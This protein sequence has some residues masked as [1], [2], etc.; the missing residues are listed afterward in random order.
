MN[1]LPIEKQILIASM[2]CEGSSIRG[3]ER[4][5]GVHRDTIMRLG[6]RFGERAK[7]IMDE[8][9]VNLKCRYVQVDE[10]WTFC[11]KKQAKLTP[12][13]KRE[14]EYGDKWVFIALDAETKLVIHFDVC[15]RKK[16]S[17]IN[18]LGELN[19][20]IKNRFQLTTDSLRSYADAVELVWG[21]DIH[22]GQIHK[23]YGRGMEGQRYYSPPEIIGV[24]K[25]SFSGEPNINK[26]STSY[27]ESQNLNLRMGMRRLTRLV[28]SF[29]KKITNLYYATALHFFYV[30]FIKIHS[31][32]RVSPAMEAGVTNHLW[33]WEDFL[34][35]SKRF[36]KVA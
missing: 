28:N 11:K 21:G 17:I 29:S 8:Y 4:V 27:V 6:I 15:D 16:A 35:I 3:I 19:T 10:C 13:E 34:G 7:K 30:N 20:K 23:E 12:L 36:N 32:L 9:L 5:T 31:S 25:Q 18:F 24:T 2:L 1:V 26:I 22:Y 33:T 14:K